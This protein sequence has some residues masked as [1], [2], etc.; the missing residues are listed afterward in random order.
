MSRSS[1]LAAGLP[2]LWADVEVELEY[3]PVPYSLPGCSCSSDGADQFLSRASSPPSLNQRDATQ[4][5]PWA[6]CNGSLLLPSIGVY[7]HEGHT[8]MIQASLEAK[9]LFGFLVSITYQDRLVCLRMSRP[10]V[11]ACLYY[12]LS[13]CSWLPDNL[14]FICAWEARRLFFLLGFSVQI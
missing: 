9:Q 4:Q 2:P 10:I 6:L 14:R 8:L 11:K 13:L 3:F 7:C 1:M 12:M 5:S